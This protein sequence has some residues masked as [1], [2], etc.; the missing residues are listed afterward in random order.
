MNYAYFFNY[1]A[2][3][4]T[5]VG[6]LFFS[7]AAY[8][9]IVVVAWTLSESLPQ[10]A[11][12]PLKR[13]GVQTIVQRE[14]K[15]PEKMVGAIFPHSNG[16]ISATEVKK[17]W[18]LEF[19][20]EHDQGIYFW[21]FGASAYRALLGVSTESAIFSQILQ[22]NLVEGSYFSAQTDILV[23]SNYAEKRGLKLGHSVVLNGVSYQIKGILN[24]NMSG[25][26]IP[27]D[28]YLTIQEARK[29]VRASEQIR[30]LY[31]IKDDFFNVI[32]LK[33]DPSW[34]GKKEPLIKQIDPKLLIFSEKSFSNEIL[35]QLKLVSSTG[36]AML[37]V[38]GGLL[39][40]AFVLMLLFN[41]KTREKELAIL[42]ML[43]W[44]IRDLKK[45]LLAEGMVILLA[46]L[47]FGNM[48][49]YAGLELLSQQTI[50]LELPWDISARPHFLPEENNI[51]R[52][53]ESRIPVTFEW[54][55]ALLVTSGFLLLFSG[56]YQLLFLRLKRM[57]PVTFQE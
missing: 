27:A 57:T 32:L 6:L 18:N 17:I 52:I 30:S 2:N 44:G 19:V 56:L 4:K 25:N 43:G 34:R 33:S 40:V 54:K 24:S 31:Q 13:I 35:D 21:F 11:S 45:Q 20:E 16:P 12:V 9:A 53:I 23:T 8:F 47:L 36:K 42:R 3:Q 37:I 15:I 22:K 1:L 10:I 38:L 39:V 55:T 51:D 46:A 26:I 7:L 49:A 29:M 41:L 28:I 48:I 14:G 5:K 50:Q